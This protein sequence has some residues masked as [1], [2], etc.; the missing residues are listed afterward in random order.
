M[1]GDQSM[2]VP[3]EMNDPEAGHD[4]FLKSLARH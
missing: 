3:K 2:V 4:E 1:G